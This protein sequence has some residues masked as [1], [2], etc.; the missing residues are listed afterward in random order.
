MISR[1]IAVIVLSGLVI[2]INLG[3]GIYHLT[4]GGEGSGITQLFFAAVLL[5]ATVIFF[6]KDREQ[7]QGRKITY[8]RLAI[9]SILSVIALV[10][11]A[12]SIY[13]FATG[14]I[15]SGT[16]E[17]IMAALLGIIVYLMH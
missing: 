10:L 7:G 8:R 6:R 13:H 4:H 11:F 12:L 9:R 5:S 3:A 15:P 14:G 2:V 1:R 16:A 17:M